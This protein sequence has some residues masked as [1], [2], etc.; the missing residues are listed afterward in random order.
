[1]PSGVAF[2]PMQPVESG[3]NLVDG[4]G[5][6]EELARALTQAAEDNIGVVTTADRDDGD[7]RI[8]SG[9]VGDER[10]RRI[11]ARADVEEAEIGPLCVHEI[12]Q[13]AA[14][15]VGL[16]VGKGGA[17]CQIGQNRGK[18]MQQTAVRT[19]NEMLPP[20]G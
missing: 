13:G 17:G 15:R 19:D 3:A 20:S 11:P 16:K 9:K 4:E 7:A 1:M 8:D 5:L 10:Y 12:G 18:P 14:G 2:E 6:E